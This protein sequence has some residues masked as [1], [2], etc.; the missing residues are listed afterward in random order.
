MAKST[1]RPFVPF[2]SYPTKKNAENTGK[3]M[4]WKCVPCKGGTEDGKQRYALIRKEN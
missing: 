1:R 4:P 2:G 3:R